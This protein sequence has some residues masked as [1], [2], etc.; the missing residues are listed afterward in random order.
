MTSIEYFVELFLA[1]NG[2]AGELVMPEKSVIKEWTV[3]MD[4]GSI[5]TFLAREKTS[6]IE[7]GVERV[8]LEV[9]DPHVRHESKLAEITGS[10]IK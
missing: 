6:F 7:N 1:Q 8:I 10:L 5:R 3:R 4:D 2:E 9:F